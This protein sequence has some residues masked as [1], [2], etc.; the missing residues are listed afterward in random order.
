MKLITPQCAVCAGQVRK[1]T[2]EPPGIPPGDEAPWRIGIDTDA[3]EW[4]FPE[5]PRHA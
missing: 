5:P 1:T 4:L 3:L 2:D